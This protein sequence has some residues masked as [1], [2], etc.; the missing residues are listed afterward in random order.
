MNKKIHTIQLQGK[1]YAQVK[2]RIK[3]FRQDCPNGKIETTPQIM[4]DGKVLFK[5][6]ILKD[7]GDLNSADATGHAL[8]TNTGIKAFEKLESIAVGRALAL[9]GYAMDGE[10]ASG[11]EMQEFMNYQEDKKK[12][13]IEESRSKLEAAESLDDL[14]KIWASLNPEA[15]TSLD[16]IKNELKKKYENTAISN[17]GGVVGSEKKEDNRKSA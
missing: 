14:A 9:L 5:A 8:G 15:K 17:G 3:E 13:L 4:E 6:Y 11:E 1:D 12:L 7:K 16:S 10:I 2:D